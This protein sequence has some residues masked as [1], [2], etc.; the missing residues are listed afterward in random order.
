[1]GWVDIQNAL[2]GE[3]VGGGGV[4]SEGRPQGG[5]HVEHAL[6]NQP[7]IGVGPK[8]NIGMCPLVDPLSF[9]E[10]RVMNFIENPA[11]LFVDFGLGPLFH[12]KEDNSPVKEIGAEGGASL[13]CRKSANISQTIGNNDNI[14]PNEV[15]SNVEGEDSI[16]NWATN[17]APSINEPVG[18]LVQ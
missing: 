9:N 8:E 5:N 4:Q 15:C 10:R 13:G 7:I 6:V 18:S 12:I 1:M 16:S 11:D 14:G 2:E 3:E 17:I